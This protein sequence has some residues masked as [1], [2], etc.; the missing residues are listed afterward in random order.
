MAHHLVAELLQDARQLFLGEIE[1]TGLNVNHAVPG[2]D[3]HDVGLLA[4]RTAGVGRAINTGLRESRNQL[5]H[6]H[7]HAA[8]VAR[9]RLGQGRS[10]E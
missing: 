3:L 1:R 8:T 7:V 4:T 10:M 5:A 9:A 6:V 2:L